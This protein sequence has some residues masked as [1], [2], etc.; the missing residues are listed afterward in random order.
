MVAMLRSGRRENGLASR[1][2]SLFLSVMPR[3]TTDRRVNR[4]AIL[5]APLAS[6]RDWMTW[7]SP[8]Y[9]RPAARRIAPAKASSWGKRPANG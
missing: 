9:G 3:L 5:P 4:K 6:G 7:R 8:R 2:A 1:Q